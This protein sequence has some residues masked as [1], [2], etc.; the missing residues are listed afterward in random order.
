MPVYGKTNKFQV[1]CPIC[2]RREIIGIPESRLK[3]NSPLTTISIHKGLICEHHF[4]FFLDKNFQIRG[5]QKVD[6]E[7]QQESSKTLRNGIKVFNQNK[8][9]NK[10]NFENLFPEGEKIKLI[11][12]S[13]EKNKE[14]KTLKQTRV[15]LS[16]KK[17]SLKEIYEEF[18]EFIDD[19]NKTFLDYITKDKRRSKNSMQ[20]DFEELCIT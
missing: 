1:I 6:L 12:L 19:S 20:P 15:L 2:K 9:R 8:E 5:Y 7:L 17:K 16:S 3:N 18:W 11:P 14:D 13:E 4:Q 10:A